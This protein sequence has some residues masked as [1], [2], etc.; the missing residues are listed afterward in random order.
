MLYFDC[1]YQKV[2]CMYLI[3]QSVR[4]VTATGCSNISNVWPVPCCGNPEALSQMCTGQ[5]VSCRIFDR[6][7]WRKRW[8]THV[9]G[10]EHCEQDQ[11]NWPYVSELG[12]WY[13]FYPKVAHPTVLVMCFKHI[14][15]SQ[16]HNLHLKRCLIY[17]RHQPL[18][19]CSPLAVS[20]NRERLSEEEEDVTWEFRAAF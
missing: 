5:S 13:H 20:R 12:S 10:G 1:N 11:C 4:E 14:R 9:G 16:L 18:G 19:L 7:H 17:L 15:C 8:L 3:H 2:S 6:I